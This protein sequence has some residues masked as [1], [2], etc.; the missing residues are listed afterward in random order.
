MT[1]ALVPSLSPEARV[2]ISP[3]V[4]ARSFGDETVLLDFGRGEYFGLDAVGGE[5]WR[6]L[7]RGE[8]LRAVADGLTRVFEVSS[9]QA[10]DDVGMLVSHMIDQGLLVVV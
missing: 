3:S 2:R 8:P 9:E 10:L 4:Y 1:M 7:E 5:I 6:A